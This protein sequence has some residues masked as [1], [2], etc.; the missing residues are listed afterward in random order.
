MADYDPEQQSNALSVSF[1]FVN[2]YLDSTLNVPAILVDGSVPAILKVLQSRFYQWVL[3]TSNHGWSQ[4]LQNLYD[5]ISE[6]CRKITLNE[7][8]VSEIQITSQEIGWNIVDGNCAA[9]QVFVSGNAPLEVN[10]L[11]FTVVSTGTTYVADTIFET[12]RSDSNA[13][14]ATINGDFD[15]Q[16][17]GVSYLNIR[18]DGQFTSGET[19]SVKGV[20]DTL[21][22]VSSKLIIQQS[23][24]LY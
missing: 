22:V 5:S 17:V 2:S 6:S 1:S 8:L 4:E 10:N 19:F 16:V 9:G 11:V 24:V 12:K 13:V 7:I 14:F 23:S 20:P 21:N 15:W 18:F 3:E